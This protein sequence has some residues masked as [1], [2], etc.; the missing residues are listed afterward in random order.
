MMLA[1]LVFYRFH[2]NIELH[3]YTRGFYMFI[4]WEKKQVSTDTYE[5]HK[6]KPILYNTSIL[7]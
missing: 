6:I 1:G 4:R 7:N 3:G 5:I 2:Y